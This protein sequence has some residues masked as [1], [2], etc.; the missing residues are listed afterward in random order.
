MKPA[1]GGGS[2][3]PTYSMQS[4]TAHR[5]AHEQHRAAGRGILDR[6]IDRRERAVERELLGHARA[7]TGQVDRDRGIAA[8]RQ[9]RDLRAPHRRG[10]PDAVHEHDLDDHA[11]G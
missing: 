8:L 10:R 4:E 5:V 11:P 9:V 1:T 3:R 7:V 2:S 6:V